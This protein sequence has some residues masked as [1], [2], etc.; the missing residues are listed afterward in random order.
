MQVSLTLLC[1]CEPNR[2]VCPAPDC[3][4]YRHRDLGREEAAQVL[5][6][7]ISLE[8]ALRE[9]MTSLKKRQNTLKSSST[10]SLQLA[11]SGSDDMAET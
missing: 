2:T 8:L 7:S 4:A 3:D 10:P 11:L 6:W 5:A 9:D 1:V